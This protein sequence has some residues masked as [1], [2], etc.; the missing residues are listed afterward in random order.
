MPLQIRWLISGGFAS[1]R[2][3]FRIV[4]HDL[5]ASWVERWVLE[6]LERVRFLICHKTAQR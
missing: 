1:Q 5:N 2:G 3:L 4:S 6:D